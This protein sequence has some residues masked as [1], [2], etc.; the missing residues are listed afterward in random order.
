MI[1]L[2]VQCQGTK[3]SLF[4]SLTTKLKVCC[5]RERKA[6]CL[7]LKWNLAQNHKCVCAHVYTHEKQW[8]NEG[9]KN[10][11]LL[12][13]SP[14]NLDFHNFMYHYCSEGKQNCYADLKLINPNFDCFSLSLSLLPGSCLRRVITE[15]DTSD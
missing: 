5:N 10:T 7:D 1:N 11:I 14:S 13:I 2:C 3:C 15:D 9:K 12:L 4:F 6:A 8:Q